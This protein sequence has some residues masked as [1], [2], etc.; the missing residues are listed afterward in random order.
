MPLYPGAV[1]LLEQ[2]VAAAPVGGGESPP[3]PTLQ[4]ATLPAGQARTIGGEDR[5]GSSAQPV[6]GDRLS[7]IIR[8]PKITPASAS[9]CLVLAQLSPGAAVCS[10]F[11]EGTRLPTGQAPFAACLTV[12]E[13][14]YAEL[15]GSSSPHPVLGVAP[16]PLLGL[17]A[18]GARVCLAVPL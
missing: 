6:A 1:W 12:G 11:P 8:R 14:F 18:A 2:P 7:S 10:P 9:R 3:P 15:S 4:P 13:P 5:Q 16:S 17:G